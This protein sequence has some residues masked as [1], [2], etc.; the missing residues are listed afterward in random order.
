MLSW[1]EIGRKNP[2]LA[3]YDY[4][5]PGLYFVTIVTRNRERWF[6]AVGVDPCID[7]LMDANVRMELSPHGIMIQTYWHKLTEKYSNI[8][9]DEFIVM[10]NHIHGIIEIMGVIQRVNVGT[11]FADVEGSKHGSTPTADG[12]FDSTSASKK[13]DLSE[14]MRWFKQM[15]TNAFMRECKKQ[16]IYFDSRLWQKKFHDRIIRGGASGLEKIR[17]YIRNNPKKWHRERHRIDPYL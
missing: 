15:T 6:G 8:R 9:L 11:R 7:P 17:E 12:A 10:P 13:I 1:K 14:M 5:K 3:G 2:R 4:S 16:R